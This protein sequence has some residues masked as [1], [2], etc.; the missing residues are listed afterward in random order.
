VLSN[1]D[2]V[3]HTTRLALE[4]PGIQGHGI[5]PASGV[6]PDVAVGLRRARAATALMLALPGSAYLYQGE[7]LGL[8]EVIDI[9][10]DARQDP[11][12]HRTAGARYGRD[13]CRVPLPWTDRAPGYG[14]TGDRDGWLPM[15]DAWKDYAR[16]RQRSDSSS[17]LNLYVQLLELRRRFALGTGELAWTAPPSTQAVA[18]RNG[19]VVVVTNFGPGVV[20]LPKGA[21]V[22]V[23]S[24]GDR[25][26]VPPDTTV[27]Y[28]LDADQAEAP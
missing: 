13:G 27:W 14:F 23:S 15:P 5:G 17:T 16:D 20:E 21:V 3:R 26:V 1:H 12:W 11:T 2:I 6:R 28:T 24:A 10:D 19:R 4:S 25:E 9:P 22:L 8:P 7:E 18:F